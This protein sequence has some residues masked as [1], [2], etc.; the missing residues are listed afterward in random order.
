LAEINYQRQKP[1]NTILFQKISVA[2]IAP[3]L[4]KAV[5]SLSKLDQIY[6]CSPTRK[7]RQIIGSIFP[8]KKWGK[9]RYFELVP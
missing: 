5:D 1:E 4:S 2:E 9:P 8:K 3:A 7:K 6:L